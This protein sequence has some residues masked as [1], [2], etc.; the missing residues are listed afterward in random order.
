[1]A[2]GASTEC[3]WD[4]RSC[5]PAYECTQILHLHAHTKI[6]SGMHAQGG[7][8]GITIKSMFSRQRNKEFSGHRLRKVKTIRH[9]LGA[10]SWRDTLCMWGWTHAKLNVNFN[11][12]E[13]V[14]LK[15]CKHACASLL[16]KSPWAFV[17]KWVYLCKNIALKGNLEL[18]FLLIY[19][20]W[21]YIVNIS[22]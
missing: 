17:T 2:C 9:K 13:Y 14:C 22:P 19:L 12:V 18:W 11:L 3:F 15:G 21:W 1:M 8:Q 7:R 16:L 10:L 5:N 20:K 4:M 6:F